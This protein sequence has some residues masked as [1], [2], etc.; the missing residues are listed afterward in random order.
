MSK[1]STALWRGPHCT[2][3][4]PEKSSVMVMSRLKLS[5]P[6]EVSISVLLKTGFVIRGDLLS[7]APV[8]AI[9]CSGLWSMISGRLLCHLPVGPWFPK[10]MFPAR[11]MVSRFRPQRPVDPPNGIVTLQVYMP[12]I[13]SPEVRTARSYPVAERAPSNMTEQPTSFTPISSSVTCKVT[14]M[15]WAVT[16]ESTEVFSSSADSIQGAALSKPQ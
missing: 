3:S 14:L 2:V 12:S 10:P 1:F 5:D 15:V 13:A 8:C 9:Q 4:T 7:P 6:A 16:E 11:S